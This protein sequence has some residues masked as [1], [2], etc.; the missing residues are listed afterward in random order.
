VKETVI[1]LLDPDMMLLRPILANG[2]LNGKYLHSREELEK[3]GVVWWSDKEIPKE[4]VTDLVREG[5]VV[6]QAYGQ[7]T[8]YLKN[9]EARIAI[10]EIFG[11]DSKIFGL[12]YDQ[13]GKIE[14]SVG[15]P[16]M[17]H[18]NDARKVFKL[19]ADTIVAVHTKIDLL[20]NMW[21]ADMTGWEMSV[22]HHGI[23]TTRLLSMM[24]SD[25]TGDLGRS[26][27][28]AGEGW[29][30]LQDWHRDTCNG[31]P[32]A[33]DGGS[34]RMPLL[35]HYCHPYPYDFQFQAWAQ[36]PRNLIFHK[37]H[38]KDSVLECGSPMPIQPPNDLKQK[39]QTDHGLDAW[40]VCA[41]AGGVSQML[42]AYK[43]KFCDAGWNASQVTPYE[44]NGGLM[45]GHGF[46][47]ESARSG[48]IIHLRSRIGLKQMYLA[49]PFDGEV[50]NSLF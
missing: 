38:V 18:I 26:D 45:D 5:H 16:T 39:E 9:P 46:P 15:M 28:W 31:G 6:S 22:G 3:E 35:A 14:T 13:D 32:W 41:L 50:P 1:V 19:W 36:W 24:V 23:K 4:G 40:L 27:H 10:A 49:E 25:P 43:N 2:Q 37:R 30:L 7:G 47:L 11:N 34:K 17:I 8:A 33:P 20:L 44:F 21:Q 29:S 48:S 12:T 42:T